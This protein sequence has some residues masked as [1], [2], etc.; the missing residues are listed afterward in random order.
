MNSSLQTVARRYEQFSGEAK[1]SIAGLFHTLCRGRRDLD[2]LV[3]QDRL[4]AAQ[5]S[6]LNTMNCEFI[7]FA[8]ELEM[9]GGGK[10]IGGDIV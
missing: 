3:Y 4:F 6:I 5:T 8:E 10:R 9:R 7:Q 1:L 2:S